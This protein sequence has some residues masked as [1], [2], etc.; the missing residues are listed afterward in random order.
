MTTTPTLLVFLKYPVAGAV[1]TRLASTIGHERAAEHYR[2]WIEL[3]LARLQSL[4]GS[5]RI[6]GCFDG[7]PQRAFAPW[8]ALVDEWWQQPEGDLGNRLR[9]GFEKWQA[10]DRPIAAIGTDCLEL[11]PSL[12][13]EAFEFLR[14]SDVVFGPA[15]DGGYYLVGASRD[16]PGFFDDIPWFTSQALAVHVSLCNQRQWSVR[17]LPP[18]RD[19]DTWADLLEYGR[20]KRDDSVNTGLP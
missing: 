16:L 1:K 5:V 13:E 11:D 3:I 7:A 8:D 17:L 15:T 12:V 4:R 18:R 9:A 2:R 10:V 20:G 19:I 14:E 6:V